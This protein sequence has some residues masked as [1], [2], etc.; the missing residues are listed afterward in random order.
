MPII[1]FHDDELVR[2]TANNLIHNGEILAN[3]SNWSS[4]RWSW[5]GINIT[6]NWEI[7]WSSIYRANGWESNAN[8]R[9][10]WGWRIAIRYNSLWW[11]LRLQQ[12]KNNIT[13]YWAKT[14]WA[15]TIYLKDMSNNSDIL[16]VRWNGI[17][18][19]QTWVGTWYPDY[20]FDSLE[21]KDGAVFGKV[22]SQNIYALS[23]DIWWTPIWTINDESEICWGYPWFVYYDMWASLNNFSNINRRYEFII[24]SEPQELSAQSVTSN[25]WTI[26]WNGFIINKYRLDTLWIYTFRLNIYESDDPGADIYLY[27]EKTITVVR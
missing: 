3:W 19:L 10:W 12:F 7:S 8:N 2:V 15:G 23:C 5:W 17:S 18:S 24:I 9:A 27:W 4:W 20:L 11:W 16:L 14:A 22:W 26:R 13:A 1:L 21:V 6:I 25:I